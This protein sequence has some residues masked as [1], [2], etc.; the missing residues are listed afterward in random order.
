MAPESGQLHRSVD[1]V[2]QHADGQD[3]V[4]LRHQR[5]NLQG[6]HP[7]H[8]LRLC[9]CLWL[10]PVGPHCPCLLSR[11]DGCLRTTLQGNYDK[12]GARGDSAMEEFINAFDYRESNPNNLRFVCTENM[13]T[14]SRTSVQT[15]ADEFS[16]IC[17]AH[18]AVLSRM[19]REN[20][21]ACTASNNY[22]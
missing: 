14:Y 2:R 10:A 20:V 9:V 7:R 16:I 18:S 22:F 11:V 13:H 4:R 5:E 19:Y 15:L 1:R 6:E 3:G 12:F 21:C 8:T 17:S